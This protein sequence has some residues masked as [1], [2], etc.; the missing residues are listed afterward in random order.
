MTLRVPK[1]IS[2]GPHGALAKLLDRLGV[3]VA[4]EVP[5]A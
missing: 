5:G 2:H 1:G 4:R 3:P